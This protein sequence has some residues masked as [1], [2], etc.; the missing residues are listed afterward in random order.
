MNVAK[1]KNN[2]RTGLSYPRS[3]RLVILNPL[4]DISTSCVASSSLT[5]MLAVANLANIKRCKT[6][7]K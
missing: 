6:P 4:Y 1:C 5:L 3:R 2:T 7:E